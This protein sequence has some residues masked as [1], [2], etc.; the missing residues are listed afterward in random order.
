MELSALKRD[1]ATVESGEWVGGIPDMGAL[2]LKV[3]GF[4]SQAYQTALGRLMRA[5]SREERERDGSIKPNASRRVMGEAMHETILLDWQGIESDGAALPYSKE[6]ALELLT[7]PT[8]GPFQE[9]V[10]FA[11]RFVDSARAEETEE[12]VKN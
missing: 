3:R 7:D 11:A 6:K 8:Y 9:A 2:R 10:A 12:I 5:V 4:S 1:V